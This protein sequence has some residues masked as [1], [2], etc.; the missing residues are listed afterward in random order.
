MLRLWRSLTI[1]RLLITACLVGAATYLDLKRPGRGTFYNPIF[2]VR[3]WSARRFPAGW[4]K[5]Q[6]LELGDSRLT[7]CIAAPPAPL[8]ISAE[9]TALRQELVGEQDSIALERLGPPT[10]VMANNVYRWVT[11]SGLSLEIRVNDDGTIR[12]SGLAR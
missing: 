4:R 8:V 7:N 11:D 5:A 12:A 6:T 10:C 3:S 1:K 9:L 2:E